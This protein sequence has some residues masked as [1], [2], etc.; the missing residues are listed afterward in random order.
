LI[1]W[2]SQN[3]LRYNA[4]ARDVL[5]EM[6]PAGQDVSARLDAL[7]N[8]Y[9]D[10]QA[11]RVEAISSYARGARCRHRAIAEHFGERMA[12]CGS[13]CD[14]CAPLDGGRRV[15]AAVQRAPSAVRYGPAETSAA[16]LAAVDELQ[17]RLGEK[18][19]VCV[20]LGTPG[21][22][23]CGAFGQLAGADF[24]AT[25]AVVSGLIAAGRLA[26]RSRALVPV[27]GTPAAGGADFAHDAVLRCLARLPFA[28]GKSGLAKVLKGAAGSPIGPD[29]CADYAALA[30]MT[31]AAIE[32][33]IERLI[34]SGEL[35]RSGERMPLL[36]ITER[37][38]AALREDAMAD[39]LG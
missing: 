33:E 20:L 7:L 35:R 25:R 24:A 10:R 23:A 9:A 13:A 17:G 38:V 1:V 26:Y 12:A 3:L 2:H 21:Y 22:P 39:D 8:E 30:H 36:A 5:L 4:A 16:A 28:V 6:R 31:G 37:G 18:D 11:A 15:A 29:R 19:L 34:A 14:M 32:A 27:R